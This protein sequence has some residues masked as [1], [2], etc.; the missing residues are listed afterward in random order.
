MITISRRLAKTFAATARRTLDLKSRASKEQIVQL[1]TDCDGLRLIAV[2]EHQALEYRQECADLPTR[3]VV[4]PLKALA[5]VAANKDDLATFAEDWRGTVTVGWQ[6]ESIARS[7]EFDPV[8]RT[9]IKTLPKEAVD[10]VMQPQELCFA[11]RE[12]FRTTDD[13]SSRFAMTC[14]QVRGEFGDVAATDGRSLYMQGGFSFP[15]RESLLVRGT[16]AFECDNL[17]GHG[18]TRMGVVG[19]HLAIKSGPWSL[20]L[21][22][23]R[24]GRFPRVDSVMPHV[25]GETPTMELGAGDRVFLRENLRALPG[26]EDSNQPITIDLN[27]KVVVR[28]KGLSAGPTEFVLSKSRH[29]SGTEAHV[30]IDRR[31]LR[32]AMQLGFTFVHVTGPDTPVVCR[33][34]YRTF[35]WAPLDK[36]QI[37]PPSPDAVIV[38]S[39]P[40]KPARQCRR[41]A[42]VA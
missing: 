7:Q 8:D 5:T 9:K 28:A 18:S 13:A 35:V 23:N 22:L 19:D 10:W 41:K 20:Y 30:A 27:E 39:T 26:S 33:D 32:R 15:F 6:D 4:A 40:H 24:E 31:Y 3:L 16:Q 34:G 38:K 29:S 1:F 2:G 17:F 25:D 14:V 42:L 37:V 36:S 21:G 12:A 11:L